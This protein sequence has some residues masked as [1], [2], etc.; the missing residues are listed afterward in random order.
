MSDSNR[1]KTS[2][3]AEVT[4]GTTPSTPT[5]LV[6]PKASFSLRPTP[7]YTESQII[8]DDANVQGVY[9]VSSGV[10]GQLDSELVYS[11]SGDAIH[12]LIA[13]AM[14]TT[15]TA[16][17]TQVTGVTSTSNVLSGGSGNVETGCEVGDIVR[18]RDSGDAL[19][20]YFR[21]G[22]INTGAHT[23]TL[24]GG[25]LADGSG[26]KIDRGARMKNGT[27]DTHFSL[28]HARLDET[29][30]EIFRGIGVGRMEVGIADEQISR[31]SFGLEGMSAARATSAYASGYTSPTNRDSMTARTVQTFQ[32]GG[33][34]YEM[35]DMTLTVDHGIAARRQVGT[36][37]PTSLRRGSTRITGTVNCYLDAWTELSKMDAGTASEL[38]VVQQDG[39]GNCWSFAI[40]Q[41]KWTDG[42]ADTRGRDQDDFK[43]LT[44]QAELDTTE[45]ISMRVQRWA[46]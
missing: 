26:R 3:I 33:T 43:R 23:M 10:Q 41:L 29:L 19:L 2:L 35:T 25:T 5:M 17:A 38:W 18:V 12:S 30:Y 13:A 1:T 21:V 9:L 11:S 46:A 44:F 20:G 14:R 34:T 40:P 28:E 39:A 37:T 7:R 42:S 15:E 27:T 16:A 8:R 6:V 45:L 31:L 4:A 36:S 22:T 32:L 24:T